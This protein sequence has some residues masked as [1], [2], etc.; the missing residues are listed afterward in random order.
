MLW[1]SADGM[2]TVFGRKSQNDPKKSVIL[3][4]FV[5]KVRYVL[6]VCKVCPNQLQE[7]QHTE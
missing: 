5:C 6:K 7:K 4:C 1:L 2:H 3:G